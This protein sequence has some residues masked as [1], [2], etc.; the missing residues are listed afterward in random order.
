[1]KASADSKRAA[2]PDFFSPQVHEA[3]RFYLKLNPPRSREA[4]VVCGGLEYTS[5]D[6]RIRR[7]HFPF[8]S[9]EYVARGRGTVELRNESN[10]PLTPTLS[11][12][13]KSEGLLSPNPSPPEEARGVN[14]ASLG[15]VHG[16][17]ART[18]LRGI[19]SPSDGEREKLS[20][21]VG[22]MVPLHARRRKGTLHVLQPG[23]VFSY[24]PGVSH[25]IS[26][27][28]AEPMVKYFVDFTGPKAKALL[29]SCGMAPG[30]VSQVF[31]ATELQ[32]LFDELIHSGLQATRGS[33][34]LCD[35]LLKC[36]ILRIR[37]ARAPLGGGETRAFET[38]QKCREH[39]Q[40]HYQRLKT[41]EQVSAECHVNNAYLC[42]LFA[43]YDH[44]S[45]YQ[46]LL[47][48]KMNLAAQLL[49]RS[50]ALVK[51][52][53][54]EL[55]FEDPFHFSRAFKREFGLS[56]DEFRRLR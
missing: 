45:P 16:F 23:R 34:A 47:R 8:Y 19:L 15:K 7:E 40:H 18:G 20:A 53:A 37:D 13:P 21:Q 36:L 50:E 49:H 43:R 5:T 51:Q 10:G 3:R 2:A 42:R 41:L 55:G 9:L 29:A 44:Q 25:E 32:N 1:M 6:Y 48:L 39:I 24:G 14:S 17:N 52:V 27:D 4:A 11:M 30:H 12:D 26:N 46:L 31:P 33:A 35:H 38:Y 28:P 54:E 56:P 22:F